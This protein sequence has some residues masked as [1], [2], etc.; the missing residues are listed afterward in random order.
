MTDRT[1]N[2]AARI[3]DFAR[4]GEVVVSQDIVD[5]G[6]ADGVAFRL[7]GPVELKGVPMALT[8]HGARRASATP[9]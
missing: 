3:A 1:V 6:G 5:A 4:L 8:L 2:L 7:I 9:A